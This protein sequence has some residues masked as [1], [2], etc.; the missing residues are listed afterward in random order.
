[1]ATSVGVEVFPI[2]VRDAAE[3]ERAPRG[4][5]GLGQWRLVTTASA[6]RLFRELIATLPALLKLRA[7]YPTRDFVASGGLVSY[8]ADYVDQYR[9]AAV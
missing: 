5:R 2:N 9:G 3:I 7:V 1:V 8:G 4:V 6:S